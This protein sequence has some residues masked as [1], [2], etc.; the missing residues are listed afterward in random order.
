MG[1]YR[2]EEETGKV[3]T[4]PPTETRETV[5]ISFYFVLGDY[6]QFTNKL[7]PLGNMG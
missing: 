3:P 5:F 4:K 2:E 7:G 6:L 1:K